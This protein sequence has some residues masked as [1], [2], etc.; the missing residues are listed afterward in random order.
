MDAVFCRSGCALQPDGIGSLK[1]ASPPYNLIKAE[2]YGQEPRTVWIPARSKCSSTDG[3]TT[4]VY[5]Y[6]GGLPF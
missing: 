4:I 1:D 5:H 2:T 3:D 6:R